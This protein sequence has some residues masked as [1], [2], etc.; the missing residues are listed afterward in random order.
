[1]TDLMLDNT[2]DLIIQ[3]GDFKTGE[4]TIQE[5]GIILRLTKGELKS[6]PLLGTDLIQLKKTKIKRFD[7]ES[8]ARIALGRDGK[9][10]NEIKQFINVV[11]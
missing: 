3:N 4:S 2:D 6:D 9:D 11:K 8:R 10:F 7:I 5:V 1:M